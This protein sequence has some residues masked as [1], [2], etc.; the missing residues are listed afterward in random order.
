[1]RC[2]GSRVGI[3]GQLCI[4]AYRLMRCAKQI[5]AGQKGPTGESTAWFALNGVVEALDS[6][7]R[8][9][10]PRLLAT[11]PCWEESKEGETA[12]YTAVD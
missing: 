2:Q 6:V 10:Q 7:S 4:V 12:A 8:W 5:R 11:E 3:I 1:M 9:S